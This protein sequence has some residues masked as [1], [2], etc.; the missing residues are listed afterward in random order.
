MK[1]LS[2]V[3]VGSLLSSVAL[4][5]LCPAQ[6]PH[7]IAEFYGT[8][9]FETLGSSVAIVGDV[10]GDGYADYLVGA[11]NAAVGGYVLAG[12]ATLRS[13]L[14]GSEIRRFDGASY[15]EY[16]GFVAALGDVDGDGIPD[17]SVAAP[18]IP[19]GSWDAA[20]TIA[21]FSG[22]TGAFLYEVNGAEANANYGL[23]VAGIGDVD[24]DG[25]SDI[26]VGVPSH[27]TMGFVHAGAV[28]IY[29]GAD[30]A[31]I[32]L[33][34]GQRAGGSLGF[35]VSAIGD[36]DGDGRADF[37][38]GEPGDGSTI[39]GA[40]RVISAWTGVQ[41][42][43]F[44]GV[45]TTDLFGFGVAGLGDTDGDGIADVAVSAPAASD[46]SHTECGAIPV[47]SGATK[48][49]LFTIRGVSDGQRLGTSIAAAGDVDLDGRGDLVVGTTV[50]SGQA[51][52]PLFQADST[53]H[54]TLGEV[55]AGGGDVDG[56]GGDDVIFGAPLADLETITL[57]R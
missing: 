18:T 45:S 44:Q 56:D 41:I 24:L 4:P 32:R 20:G 49:V 6:A 12:F 40:A 37:V 54:E 52:I 53:G 36:V 43:G 19:I 34:E 42:Y 48:G 14:D 22:A 3:V 26:A 35:S 9:A 23:R 39:P 7:V 1:R 30:G 50:Y 2:A 38:A 55:V 27:V 31:L 5:G 57:R 51:A 10:N 29:S 21:V 8:T 47:F 16:R 46:A 13:G 25:R 28:L 33:I 17:Y 15:E 11:P